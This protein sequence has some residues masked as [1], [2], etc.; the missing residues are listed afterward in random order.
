MKQNIKVIRELDRLSSSKKKLKDNYPNFIHKIRFPVYKNIEPGCEIFFEYP[1]TVFVG[2]NGC[3]KSSV[4]HALQGAPDRRSVGNFWFSTNLDPIKEN[5]GKPSCFIYEYFNKE[6][7]KFVEIIKIRVKYQKTIDGRERVNP[8]YWEPKRASVEYGMLIPRQHN[9][10]PEPG[11]LKTTRWVVP[12]INVGYLDFRSELSAFDQYFYFGEKPK[13]LVRY[14]SKQDRLRSWV[15]N[16]LTPILTG[17]RVHS[18]K[19]NKKK[20]NP[21]P[22]IDIPKEELSIISN[23]LGKNYTGCKMVEHEIFGSLGYSVQFFSEQR[24]YTEAF[25]GSGEMAVVRV[26]NIVSNAEDNSLILLD[27]PEVSLHPG[28]QKKLKDFLLEVCLKKKLQIVLCT[29]SP[30]FLESLPKKAVKVFVPNSEGKFRV[31]GN[32]CVNDAFI[33]I[34]QTVFNKIRVIVEDAAA[35]SLI[36]HTLKVL[37]QDFEELI[38]VQYYPGGE[39]SIFKDLVVHS[40]QEDDNVFVIFDGDIYQGEWP[41]VDSVSKDSLDEVIKKYCQQSVDKLNF[42]NNG[43]NDQQARA[44]VEQTKRDYLRYI[45]ERCFFLPCEIPE[46]IIWNGATI[47]GKRDIEDEISS[48]AKDRF[49]D[50]I[51][52][53]A[54]RQTGSDS[55]VDRSVIIRQILNVNFDNNNK[56]FLEIKRML[57]MIKDLGSR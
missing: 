10:R 11:S 52:L 38:D 29:H 20:L 3:G 6:A 45:S 53:Y 19:R 33:Q 50:Y 30:V 9:G 32:V 39:S 7:N 34:G 48:T 8:D 24:S 49:K 15:K 1:L 56:Y 41:S 13:N 25:A 40:R 26:V 55:S 27:E 16:Q 46:E 31:V 22:A 12:K 17:R 43:G 54:E 47:E 18:F 4:L 23:I 42:R 51:G 44:R 21:K 57:I 14:N 36:D 28:A 2:Q 37:G 5:K 35:K